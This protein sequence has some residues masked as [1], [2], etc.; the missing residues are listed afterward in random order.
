MLH[1]KNLISSCN[2]SVSNKLLGPQKETGK[3]ERKGQRR[4]KGKYPAELLAYMR[5][6]INICL[7][8]RVPNELS[9]HSWQKFQSFEPQRPR[10]YYWS[11]K[12]ETLSCE[13]K[14]AGKDMHTQQTEFP[15]QRSVSLSCPQ[16]FCWVGFVLGFWF[17]FWSRSSP[18]MQVGYAMP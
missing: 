8:I 6:S 14:A 13:Q 3:L 12:S 17:W 2:T 7:I 16:V 9:V 10:N 11:S 1:F 5:C 15:S 4:G 18:G